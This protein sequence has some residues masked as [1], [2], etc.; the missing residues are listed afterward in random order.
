MVLWKIFLPDKIW[1]K[2]T[3][4]SGISGGG[5]QSWDLSHARQPLT[6]IS[7]RNVSFYFVLFPLIYKVVTFHSENR[8]HTCYTILTLVLSQGDEELK[9]S[10]QIKSEPCIVWNKAGSHAIGPWKSGRACK[11]TI[12]CWT[13]IK[14]FAYFQHW[15]M[16]KE[17]GSVYLLCTDFYTENTTEN[18]IPHLHNLYTNILYRTSHEN[19]YQNRVS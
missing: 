19:R 15:N 2:W 16:Y 17:F 7:S 5:N 8:S 1:K 13:L 12:V 3:K 11:N 10:K 4:H 18:N 9:F 6:C 14:M